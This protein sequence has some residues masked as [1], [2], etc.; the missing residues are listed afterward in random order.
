[1]QLLEHA[2]TNTAWS[3][4]VLDAGCGMRDN[5][6]ENVNACQKAEYSSDRL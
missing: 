4:L 6:E 3:D 2:S 1:M 5:G